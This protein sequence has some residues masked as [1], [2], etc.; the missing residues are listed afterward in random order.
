MSLTTAPESVFGAVGQ[1]DAGI[2]NI[3]YGDAGPA[4]GPAVLLPHAW[5]YDI[6]SY[7]QVTPILQNLLEEAPEPSAEAVL[8][9]AERG[10]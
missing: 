5:P 4:E 8:D 3:R 6:H 9:V 2:L 1:I 7:E 10:R